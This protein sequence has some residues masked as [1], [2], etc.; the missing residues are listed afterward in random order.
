MADPDAP[1]R[2]NERAGPW[3][4]W[5]QAAFQGNDVKNGKTLGRLLFFVLKIKIL[6][7][8]DS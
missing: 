6:L 7:V 2:G 5:I 3:L 1:Q 4:H 8:F